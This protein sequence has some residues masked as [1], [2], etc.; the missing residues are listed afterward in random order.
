MPMLM[1]LELKILFFS[2]YVKYEINLS[3]Q[4][5]FVLLTKTQTLVFSYILHTVMKC[6][7]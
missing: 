7:F 3:D 2:N 5:V 4:M 6:A 1:E